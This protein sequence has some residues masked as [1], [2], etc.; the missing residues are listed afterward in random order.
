MILGKKIDNGKFIQNEIKTF[1]TRQNYMKDLEINRYVYD[2]SLSVFNTVRIN[3]SF[4]YHLAYKFYLW[5]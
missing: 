1:R 5:I 4:I 2:Q 3:L